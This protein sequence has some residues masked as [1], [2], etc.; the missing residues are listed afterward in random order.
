MKCLR[1]WGSGENLDDVR[2]KALMLYTSLFDEFKHY[3]AWA[4]MK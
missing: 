2:D 4:L 1:E 3:S